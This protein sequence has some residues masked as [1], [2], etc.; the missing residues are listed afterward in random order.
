MFTRTS[1]RAIDITGNTVITTKRSAPHNNFFIFII[2][3]VKGFLS[4]FK[5]LP[6]LRKG[7]FVRT[8]FLM[9]RV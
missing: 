6:L 5:K 4:I 7:L 1:T 8:C 3:L 2:L 9:G